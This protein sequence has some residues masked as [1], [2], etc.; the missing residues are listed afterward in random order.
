MKVLLL[1]LVALLLPGECAYADDYDLISVVAQ[2]TIY[3]VSIISSLTCTGFNAVHLVQRNPSAGWGAAGVLSGA[4]LA[5][6]SVAVASDSEINEQICWQCTGALAAVTFLLGV[7]NIT[8][9][10]GR[11]QSSQQQTVSLVAGMRSDGPRS[12]QPSLGLV[13]RF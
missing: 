13:L 3:G 11:Q 1:C 4:V 7:G 9:A 8:G 5:L 2:G 10:D 12:L 6:L